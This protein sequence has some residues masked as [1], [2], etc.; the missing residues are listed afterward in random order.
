[1]HDINENAVISKQL[2]QTKYCTD[3]WIQW[4]SARKM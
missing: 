4:V 2:N 1:M 3:V